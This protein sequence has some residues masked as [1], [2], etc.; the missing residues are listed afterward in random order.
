MKRRIF[1]GSSIEGLN[2]AYA[3]QENLEHNAEVVIWDQNIF[4]PSRYTLDDLEDIL[5]TVDFG[6]FVFTFDDVATIRGN[7][8]DI[9]RDNVVFE[10]GV[11][12]G[13]LGKEN[14]FF[15]IPRNTE[16]GHLP[17][18]LLGVTPL[19]YEAN[20]IDGNLNAALGPA[21][22]KIK[23][24]IDIAYSNLFENAK[25]KYDIL[26]NKFP[27]KRS[28]RY[29][30]TACIFNSRSIFDNCIGYPLLFSQAKKIKGLGISLNAIT[31]NWGIKNIIN[32]INSGSQI[33]LLFLDPDGSET[34]FREENEQL[35]SGTI[36]NV[37]RTNISLV[38][39]I[40]HESENKSMQVRMY[41][42]T[43]S[44]NMYIIDDN[45]IVYQHYL[46]G[47]RGQESPVFVLQNDKTNIGLFDTYLNSFR[48]IWEL[49]KEVL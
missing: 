35:P 32:L 23:K 19:T 21:C 12:I 8:S 43:P 30:D 24:E 27:N 44:L 42:Q 31:I 45:F 2:I 16:G 28:I 38:K 15:V 41:N 26:N 20:R 39:K 5:D 7:V 3:I 17:T 49:S 40:Y 6:I 14:C 33:E 48:E 22:N 46:V 47:V 13:R 34:K 18:D 1:I 11:F 4:K 37:T 29:L 25:T 10:L 9:I 36:A